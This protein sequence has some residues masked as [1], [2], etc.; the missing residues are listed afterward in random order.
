MHGFRG[1]VL[2]CAFALGGCSAVGP[3]YQSP[4]LPLQQHFVGGES[5]ALARAAQEQWWR[6]LNDPMLNHLVGRGLSQNLDLLAGYER[7]RASQALLGRTGQNAQV[8]GN[9][10][11][12]GSR[13]DNGINGSRNDSGLSVNAAY[14]FD[15][16]GG[17]RRGREQALAN[18][19]AA[20]YDVGT[21]RLA[22]L[23]DIVDSYIRA[24]YFQA[25]ASITRN[26][27]ESR[28]RTVSLVNRRREA[29]EATALEL[30]Q[31]R[32][33][34]SSAQA[35]LPYLVASFESNVYH[36]ATLLAEPAGPILVKMQSGASQPRPQ[37][38]G[39]AGVP[40]DLLRNRPD[41]RYAERNFAAATAAIGVAEAQLYPALTLDG[42]ITEGTLD[43]WRF[44]TALALPLLN[45]GIL[46]ASR[47]LAI[48]Q[49]RQAQMAWRNA[50]LVAVEDVQSG[51]SLT[52]RWRVQMGS[53]DV[54]A[55]E[56][57][58]VLAL[59]QQSYAGGAIILTDVLDSERDDASNQLA[60]AAGAR[61]YAL[62]WARLQVATGRGWYAHD[63]SKAPAKIVKKDG[64]TP[65]P[66]VQ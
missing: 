54:A 53:L 64:V 35:T 21:V 17:V 65:A 1:T 18:Y 10:A 52:K 38:I 59:S 11:A 66:T 50:V 47:N 37:W 49:A 33:L 60:V 20:Q 3:D 15:L 36:I 9:A 14:V 8:S 51:L 61:D 46:K 48:S 58:R 4:S 44:G 7:I 28:R 25:A 39:N 24:R 22:Y 57:S 12:Q 55:R 56:S 2:G 27:I 23:A 41:V 30:A 29:G 26:T 43:T 32:S 40:A 62:S 63:G 19:E 13:F 45:R 5:T 42:S 31:A 6:G 34:L 16:F